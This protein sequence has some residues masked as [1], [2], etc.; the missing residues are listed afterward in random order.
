MKIINININVFFFK[1][2]NF[3]LKNK[4]FVRIINKANTQRQVHNS[5]KFKA[6]KFKIIFVPIPPTPNKPIIV[7]LLIAHSNRYNPKFCKISEIGTQ[8]KVIKVENLLDEMAV[9]DLYFL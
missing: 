2:F 7:E 1:S 8:I 3:K 9:I 5:L 4:A 6:L